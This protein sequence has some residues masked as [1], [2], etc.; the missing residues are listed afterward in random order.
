MPGTVYVWFAVL[1]SYI[2]ITK[3]TITVLAT[4]SESFSES[5][6]P[7]GP[8]TS[9]EYDPSYQNIA[10]P[11]NDMFP[12]S[13]HNFTEKLLKSK[14]PWIVVFHDGFM[15]RNWQAMAESLRGVV[16]VGMVNRLVE[17]T[18][19]DEIEYTTLENAETII[20]PYGDKELKSREIARNANDAKFKALKSLPD[21]TKRLDINSLQGFL[22]ESYMATPSRFP[23]I[24]ITVTFWVSLAA[25]KILSLL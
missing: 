10:G 22:L 17:K 6:G 5:E 9:I 23:T 11:Y 25:D 20:Y 3:L 15:S 21:V 24:I 7:L 2:G 4:T 1:L 16:W 18:L 19:L 8:K 13:G 14:D 12:L